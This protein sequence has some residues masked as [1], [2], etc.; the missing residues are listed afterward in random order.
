MGQNQDAVYDCVR[1]LIYSDGSYADGVTTA[2]VAAKTKLQRTNT[3]AL[4]NRL[5]RAGQ[6]KKVKTRPVRYLINEDRPEPDAFASLIGATGSLKKAIQLIKA[7]VLYPSGELNLQIAAQ[8]GSGTSAVV[9]RLIQF[10]EA[11]QIIKPTAPHIV[12]NCR[13]YA[14]NI[15]GLDTVLFGPTGDYKDSCFDQARGGILF[16][17][18]YEYLEATQQAK[19]I[20][21]LDRKTDAFNPL[22][23]D[24]QTGATSPFM[25]FSCANQANKQLEGKLPVTVTLPAVDERPLS[26]KLELISHFFIGEAK[27][28][29]RK[30]VV[31]TE[32]MKALLLAD[33]FHNVKDLLAAVTIAC[34][35]AYVRVVNERGRDI[36]VYVDDLKPATQKALLK[37]KE[38]RPVLE[39][40]FEGRKTLI[41]NPTEAL[42][43]HQTDPDGPDLY[44]DINKQYAQLVDQGVGS[45][46]I[47]HVINDHIRQLFE[48]YNYDNR[49]D[50]PNSYKQLEKIVKPVIIEMVRTWL[51]E[52]GAILHRN[53]EPSVFYGL[54][55]HINSLLTIT[56]TTERMSATQAKKLV[57][58]YPVE[59][60]QSVKL[61]Q[62]LDDELALTLSVEETVLIMMFLIDAKDEAPTGHPVVLYI[63][64]GNG[65]AKSLMETTNTLNQNHYAYG[66]DMS[67][68]ASTTTALAEIKALIRK[69]DQGQGVIVIYDM[70]SIKV[71]IDTIAAE[72]NITLRAIQ[73]PITLIGIDA[74]RKSAMETDIDYVYHLITTDANNLLKANQKKEEIIVTLCHTGEG[75]A[76]QLKDYIDQN[77]H[78]GMR[79]KPLAISNKQELTDAVIALRKIYQI[80]AFVGATDP[81]LFGIPYISIAKI[82]EHSRRQLDAVLSFKPVHSE[83]FAYEQI[84]AYFREQFRFTNVAKLKELMPDLM[85]TLVTNYE[86]NE[87]QRIGLFVHLGSLVERTLSGSP[88]TVDART[89]TLT[90]QYPDDYKLLR[91][92][93]KPLEKQFKFFITD[94]EIA[95]VLTVVKQL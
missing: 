49:Y 8:S 37:E 31:S 76:I 27:T 26:E 79:V 47:K 78:L 58:Q 17:N 60:R 70:G 85:D 64:H 13:N 63:M 59:Y 24:G 48:R 53:F 23:G 16:I 91:R 22:V 25:I 39:A 83:H 69:I 75:G 7:A 71:M 10:A 94:D 95:T 65:T 6:L 52:C 45:R 11:N 67:L 32:V 40:L 93:L 73:I 55:L 20:D 35:K 19:I 56:V 42:M 30:V 46:N 82:F 92:T 34:A 77:S 28:A 62:V 51:D 72:T 14:E 74:A 81:Q 88:A 90:H 1:E 66:Y 3:S 61:A 9:E 38:N 18:H 89:A 33:Y 87:D 80:H 36:N 57:D 2:V 86:L 50:R 4:L 54:C 5:V 21:L 84:Y 12:V 44:G 29:K 43:P 15:H 41:F 68:D